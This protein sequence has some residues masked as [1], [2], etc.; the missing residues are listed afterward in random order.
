H[1]ARK[2]VRRGG[3]DPAAGLLRDLGDRPAQ[4]D[5]L[6]ARLV[7][8]AADLAADLDLRLH[9]LLLELVAEHDAPM[10]QHLLDVRGQL[11]RV[12]VDDLVFFFDAKGQRRGGHGS[13]SGQRAQFSGG[14]YTG[15]GS[16]RQGEISSILTTAQRQPRRV[17]FP[18]LIG[19]TALTCV[20]W[21][22]S[23]DTRGL[24]WHSDSLLL[25]TNPR[26]QSCCVS[27]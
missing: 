26:L 27:C 24:G 7:D 13:L 16:L 17:C 6:G 2:R 18:H 22:S 15:T 14:Y 11:P 25:K 23:T 21:I 5:D 10:I 19:P 3:D 1:P 8:V 9:K 12:G 20:Q 4:A